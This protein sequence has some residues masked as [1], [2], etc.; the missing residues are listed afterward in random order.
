MIKSALI[1]SALIH[2][3][4]DDVQTQ[5]GGQVKTTVEEK[6]KGRK[7]KKESKEI[8][9]TQKGCSTVVLT[10]SALNNHIALIHSRCLI[11]QKYGIS[12]NKTS[13][14]CDIHDKTFTSENGVIGHFYVYHDLV[15]P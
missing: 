4:S 12:S 6:R 10:Q 13:W 11:K 1:F 7:K 2:P 9:C 14:R 8:Q 5:E 15:N 3:V